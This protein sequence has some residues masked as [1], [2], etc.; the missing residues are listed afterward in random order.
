MSA[1][2]KRCGL[3]GSWSNWLEDND[4]NLVLQVDMKA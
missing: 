2:R 4:V 3:E 1:D